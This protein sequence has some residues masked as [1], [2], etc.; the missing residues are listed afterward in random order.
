MCEISHR[1]FVYI[2]EEFKRDQVLESTGYM[3]MD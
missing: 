1:L 3:M 2:G